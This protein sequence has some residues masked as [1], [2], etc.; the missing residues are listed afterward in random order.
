MLTNISAKRS[1]MKATLSSVF[2]V[3]NKNMAPVTSKSRHVGP[4]CARDGSSK[5]AVEYK[6]VVAAIVCL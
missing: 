6:R 4:G 3:V 5:A 2:T 1:T